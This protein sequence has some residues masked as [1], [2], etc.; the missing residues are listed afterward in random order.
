MVGETDGFWRMRNSYFK[1]YQIFFKQGDLV[2]K[3]NIQ[4]EGLSMAGCHLYIG[5][6][7]PALY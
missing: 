6:S 1:E 7:V 3:T 4:V 5:T 2:P